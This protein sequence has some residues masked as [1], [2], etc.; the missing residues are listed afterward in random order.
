MEKETDAKT[1]EAPAPT[2]AKA[3]F[4]IKWIIVGLLALVIIG[5]GAFVA[6]RYFSASDSSSSKENSAAKAE[7]KEV[8]VGMMYSMEPF[9]V[10][11]LDKGGKRYLK[12]KMELEVPDE[13]V[14]Q[15]LVIRKAQLRD[16]VLLLLTSKKFEDVNRLDGK[17]QLRN[18]LIF[19]I[20]QVLRTG[21]VQAL[22]FTE[23]VVQ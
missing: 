16:T 3:T 1:T 23:F 14:S 7:E 9:I 22:Y 18:E 15:E 17:F 13:K 4:P 12:V 11:L 6:L 19:R 8:Q 5:G 21:K 10:N 20:N 2:E